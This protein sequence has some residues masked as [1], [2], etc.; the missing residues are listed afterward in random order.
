M[1]TKGT[2]GGKRSSKFRFA[3]RIYLSAR[4]TLAPIPDVS[5]VAFVLFVVIRSDRIDHQDHH[6]GDER[7]KEECRPLKFRFAIRIHS[8]AWQALTTILT[9]DQGSPGTKPNPF[10]RSILS[11]CILKHYAQIPKIGTLK[12]QFRR[13]G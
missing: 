13:S 4:Q 6:E 5:I 3:K 8:F 9:E 12:M 1:D 11:D 2:K 10:R 7:H